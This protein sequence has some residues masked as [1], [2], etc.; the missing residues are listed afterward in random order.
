MGKYFIGNHKTDSY[1][2]IPHKTVGTVVSTYNLSSGEA[3]RG[4]IPGP[5]SLVYLLSSRPVKS[6]VSKQ[7]GWH[8][9]SE[10]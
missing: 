1:P 5:A 2:Q 7:D 6:R 8:F 3:E 10:E 9:L 4:R